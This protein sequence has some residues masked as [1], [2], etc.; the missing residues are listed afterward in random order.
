MAETVN[1]SKSVW[2][3]PVQ[4]TPAPVFPSSP[5]SAPIVTPPAIFN[6]KPSMA[7]I[8]EDEKAQKLRGKQAGN[9]SELDY[10]EKRM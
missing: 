3:K 6:R 5:G 10:Q 4:S 1:T 7:E 9:L 8:L 2:G